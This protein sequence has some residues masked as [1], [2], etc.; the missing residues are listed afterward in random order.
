MFCNLGSRFPFI[1]VELADCGMSPAN[2][3]LGSPSHWYSL[4][5]ASC[6]D[7]PFLFCVSLAAPVEVQ[8]LTFGLSLA[9][10]GRMADR[11]LHIVFRVHYG[12]I[13]ALTDEA[14][15]GKSLERQVHNFVW[16]LA[17]GPFRSTF[18]LPHCNLA[19]KWVWKSARDIMTI[20]AVDRDFA[21]ARDFL[22]QPD[23]LRRALSPTYLPRPEACDS[24]HEAFTGI[25]IGANWDQDL[26]DFLN[27]CDD[28]FELIQWRLRGHL[29]RRIAFLRGFPVPSRFLP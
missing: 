7:G 16:N 13:T 17:S 22:V 29:V 28:H 9:I 23:L 8:N 10:V 12:Y 25:L 18:P 21:M 14:L 27:A 24:W 1:H 2:V 3:S 20:A 6:A 15:R 26:D 4:F 11:V 5:L 19:S